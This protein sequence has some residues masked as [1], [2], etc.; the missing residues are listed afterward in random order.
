MAWR[1]H[2]HWCCC[3]CCS[4]CCT[5]CT[6]Q[7]VAHRCTMRPVAP[8]VCQCI[9]WTWCTGGQRPGVVVGVDTPYVVAPY[10]QLPPVHRAT[11]SAARVAVTQPGLECT[12]CV[13][14]RPGISHRVGHHPSPHTVE[15][16]AGLHE[17]GMRTAIPCSHLDLGM[18]DGCHD[19][20]TERRPAINNRS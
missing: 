11:T 5:S 13:A 18:R 16:A 4:C 3:S 8:A 19:M 2:G 1:G 15:A 14:M 20:V 10:S 17:A 7:P 9:G 12:C 6:T